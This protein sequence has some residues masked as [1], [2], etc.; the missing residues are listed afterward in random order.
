MKV[1]PTAPA[2]EASP[3]VRATLDSSTVLIMPEESVATPA[4]HRSK[5]PLVF[6]G[7]GS[8]RSMKR[9]NP[10]TIRSERTDSSVVLASER[11]PDEAG[12]SMRTMSPIIPRTP[13]TVTTTSRTGKDRGA[14]GGCHTG[15]A[16]SGAGAVM[17]FDAL[18][19]ALLILLSR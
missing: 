16:S 18:I 9:R 17:P 14:F 19:L 10:P 7:S 5:A 13:R 15:A 12:L 11:S 8:Q 2:R 1:A 4:P 6:Q 3:I